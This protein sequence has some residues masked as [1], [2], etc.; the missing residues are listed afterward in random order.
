MK[1]I[2][3]I[4]FLI[5][6]LLIGWAIGSYTS[7]HFYNRW[8]QRY[9]ARNA[10]SGVTDRLAALH[11]LR[12][13]D[14]NQVVELLESQMDGQIMALGATMQEASITERPAAEAQLLT[15]LRDYRAAY[16]RKTNR[17]EID[18]KVTGILS[19]TN[20]QNQP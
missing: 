15:R 13:D 1:K 18:Q 12:A 17:P 14:T 6:A 20:A 7:D 2:R 16:P 10:I 5:L 19:I 9:L 11:A 8:I 4:L 3:P